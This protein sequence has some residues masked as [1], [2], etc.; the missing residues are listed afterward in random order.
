EVKAKEERKRLVEEQKRALNLPADTEVEYF[1]S[2]T[3]KKP[4]DY[5][6]V[7]A[8]YLEKHS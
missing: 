7:D 3:T 2:D 8:D 6:G 5:E 4:D 1:D